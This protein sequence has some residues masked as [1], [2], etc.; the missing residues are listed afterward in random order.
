MELI[1][2]ANVLLAALLKEAIT[3]ELLLDSRLKLYAPEYLISE[4]L[5]LIKKN[6]KIQKRMGLSLKAI[7]EN[8][9]LLTQEIETY[10]RKTYASF[11]EEAYK[12]APHKEDASY[13]ALALAL[14]LP[15]WSND[16][17]IQAQSRVKVYSTTRLIISLNQVSS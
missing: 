17:G 2:D 13:L 8:F 14:N 11:M 16:K 10:P 6:T 9:Y 5:H 7:E 1:V 3:R 12:I 4:T 15:V